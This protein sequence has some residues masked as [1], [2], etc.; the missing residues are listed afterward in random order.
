MKTMARN[1]VVQYHCSECEHVTDVTI[2]PRIP[3]TFNSPE[4]GGDYEP[5]CCEK[6][7]ESITDSDIAELSAAAYY[8]DLAAREEAWERRVYD[9]Y[10]EAK[11]LDDR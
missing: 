4:E 3:A 11:T 9:D 10:Y 7:G 2:Y 1:T 8:D 6:C 5:N